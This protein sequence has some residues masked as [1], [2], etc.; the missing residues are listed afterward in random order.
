MRIHKIHRVSSERMMKVI[1]FRTPLGLFL[2]KEG[3][4]WVAVDNSTGDVWTEEF[5]RKRQA[6]RWLRGKFEVG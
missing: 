4:K 5:S 2:T 1:D 6:I 3:G